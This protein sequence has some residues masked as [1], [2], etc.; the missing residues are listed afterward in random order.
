MKEI[1]ELKFMRDQ[2]LRTRKHLTFIKRWGIPL[3]WA[4]VISSFLSY[5]VDLLFLKKLSLTKLTI[6]II[7][8]ST[9]IYCLY[10]QFKNRKAATALLADGEGII[11]GVERDIGRMEALIRGE[12][13]SISYEVHTVH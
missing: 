3:T 2:M 7:L 6:D 5:G 8:L 1:E 4:C 13:V 11:N 12:V 10:L 9:Q